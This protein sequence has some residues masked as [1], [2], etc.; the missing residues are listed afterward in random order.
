VHDDASI[1]EMHLEIL[2]KPHYYTS[3]T[4]VFWR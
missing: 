3:F 4:R 1:I 2:W